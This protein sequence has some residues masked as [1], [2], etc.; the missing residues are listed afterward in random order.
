[1]PLPYFLV[2]MHVA[3]SFGNVHDERWLVIVYAG[4]WQPTTWMVPG[5]YS[6]EC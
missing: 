2:P 4:S 1:M 3:G 6:E 5:T